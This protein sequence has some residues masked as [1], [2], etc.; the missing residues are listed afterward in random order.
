MNSPHSPHLPQPKSHEKSRCLIGGN[1]QLALLE[2]QGQAAKD[3]KNVDE[4]TCMYINHHKSIQ[5]YPKKK[6]IIHMQYMYIYIDAI[7]HILYLYS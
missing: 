4:S 1:D 7:I 3:T 2:S 6:I 5:I